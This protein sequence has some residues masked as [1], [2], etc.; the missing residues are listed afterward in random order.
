[1]TFGSASFDGRYVYL[2]TG[3]DNVSARA[4]IARYDTT[5]VFRETSSWSYVDVLSGTDAGSDLYSF[6]GTTFDG[7]YVYA[8]G[9]DI[10]TQRTVLLFRVDTAAPFTMGAVQ[11]IAFPDILRLTSP[12]V[13]LGYSGMAFDG[14]YVYLSP[15]YGGIMA[16]FDARSPAAP[17]QI[18]GGSFY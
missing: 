12:P 1:V 2:F 11:S 14:R 3:H 18:D 5:M 15:L 13:P 17:L 10:S 8:L 7:R 16:R 9:I 6:A 4:T